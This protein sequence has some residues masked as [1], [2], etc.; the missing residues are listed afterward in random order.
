[1][2]VKDLFFAKNPG[3][4]DAGEVPSEQ[5]ILS[6]RRVLHLDLETNIA[7]HENALVFDECRA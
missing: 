3:D 2:N 5:F 6:N 7:E 4:R 1:M